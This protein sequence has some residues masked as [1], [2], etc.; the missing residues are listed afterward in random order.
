[1]DE[2]EMEPTPEGKNGVQFLLYSQNYKEVIM[3]W[4]VGIA[5]LLGFIIGVMFSR[6]NKKKAEMIDEGMDNLA[7][8]VSDKIKEKVQEV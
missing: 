8:K 7:D 6:H 4:I 2:P 1:M 3:W 5:F